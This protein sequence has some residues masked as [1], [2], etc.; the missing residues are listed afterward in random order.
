MSNRHRAGVQ[1]PYPT[2][3]N[4]MYTPE[5][6]IPQASLYNASSLFVCTQ[7]EKVKRVV[8]QKHNVSF[9]DK[10]TQII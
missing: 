1:Y 3:M 7:Q 9:A 8:E 6:C 10:G 4:V 2:I 5:Q